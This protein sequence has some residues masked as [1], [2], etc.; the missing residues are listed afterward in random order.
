[1]LCDKHIVRLYIGEKHD[2][3][4]LVSFV[5]KVLRLVYP[6]TPERLSCHVLTL[7]PRDLHGSIRAAGFITEPLLWWQTLSAVP[8]FGGPCEIKGLSR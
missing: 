1:M 3:R 6:R 5:S 8:E 7:A 2:V 4:Q